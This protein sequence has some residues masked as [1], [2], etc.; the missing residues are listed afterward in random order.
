MVISI[1]DRE[2]LFNT[3][4]ILGASRIQ[5]DGFVMVVQPLSE[6]DKKTVEETIKVIEAVSGN[7]E[8]DRLPVFA[9]DLSLLNTMASELGTEK[10]AFWPGESASDPVFVRPYADFLDGKSEEKGYGIIMPLYDQ[11]AKKEE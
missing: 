6:R 3:P 2:S 10:V 9:L 4:V 1:D 8:K 11:L 7:Q 5:A